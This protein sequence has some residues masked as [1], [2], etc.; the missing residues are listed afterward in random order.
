M[1][2]SKNIITRLGIKPY[3]APTT[4]KVTIAQMPESSIPSSATK[5]YR[6]LLDIPSRKRKK[7]KQYS[8]EKEKK[9]VAFYLKEYLNN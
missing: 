9:N 5:E 7:D 1:K 2:R 8:M 3:V 6:K 4:L